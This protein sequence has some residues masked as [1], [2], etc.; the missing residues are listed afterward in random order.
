MALKS[1]K[2]EAVVLDYETA[3]NYTGSDLDGLKSKAIAVIFREDTASKKAL[4]LGLKH[5]RSGLVW[6]KSYANAY[7][8]NIETIQCPASGDAGNL[9]F[10][11]DTDGSDNLEQIAS[12][13]KTAGLADDTTGTDADK[14]YP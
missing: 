8:K 4:G 2:V 7:N 11:V 14:R 13:L 3:K 12:F 1:R 6:C 9:T 5:N 10:T